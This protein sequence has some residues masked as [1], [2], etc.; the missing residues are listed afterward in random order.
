M[1][2]DLPIDVQMAEIE[3]DV[4]TY[5][6]LP[7]YKPA[8]TRAQVEKALDMLAAAE[9]PLHRRRRRRSSTPTPPTCSSSSPS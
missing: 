8:A 9:R 6:P 1:L 4:E 3:F 5:A 2:I 7:V